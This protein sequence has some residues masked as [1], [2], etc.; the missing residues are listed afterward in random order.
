METSDWFLFKVSA[1][2]FFRLQST[3]LCYIV[4]PNMRD[5]GS[6]GLW[7]FSGAIFLFLCLRTS[8]RQLGRKWWGSRQLRM[9][10]LIWFS[11]IWCQFQ[12][13]VIID[14][15][16][17]KKHTES[18][19]L[20]ALTQPERELLSN[21]YSTRTT[22]HM[23]DQTTSVQSSHWVYMLCYSLA[24]HARF[25]EP[26]IVTFP[27]RHFWFV[28]LRTSWRQ[29]GKNWWGSRQLRM[30]TW[31][32][33]IWNQLQFLVIIDYLLDK[34]HRESM[35]YALTQPEQ[36]LLSNRYGSRTNY[37][38]AHYVVQVSWV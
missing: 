8:R 29:L 3:D 5:F 21:R 19:M 25:Y 24:K 26:G 18:I 27:R 11:L 33:L 17:G 13:L 15:F 7:P 30:L 34:K 6:Q 12:F 20:Y 10:I 37:L 23:H 31:F 9:L 36:E 32:S 2:A 16:W 35:L 1:W 4:S 38:I 14:Y 28:C 22:Q